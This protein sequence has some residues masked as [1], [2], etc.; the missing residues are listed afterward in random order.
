MQV[1]PAQ[2]QPQVAV[3][4]SDSVLVQL[5]LLGERYWPLYRMGLLPL[6]RTHGHPVLQ[7]P[8]LSHL[9][10]ACFCPFL[11]DRLYHFLDLM[12][13]RPVGYI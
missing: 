12:L 9:P 10:V 4:V 13:W 6:G 8:A 3:L 1:L 5:V 2:G 7:T 11:L